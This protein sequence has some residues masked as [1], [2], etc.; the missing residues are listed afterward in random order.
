MRINKNLAKFLTYEKGGIQENPISIILDKC[1]LIVGW[2]ERYAIGI[3]KG[4]DLL[5]NG[6]RMGRRCCLDWDNTN[7]LFF[8]FA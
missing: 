8:T 2:K 7:S 6:K 3:L 4:Y 1:I 5:D